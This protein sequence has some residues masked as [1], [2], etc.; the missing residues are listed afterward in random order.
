MAIRQK[1]GCTYADYSNTIDVRSGHTLSGYIKTR[2]P[3]HEAEY[4][5]GIIKH[6][7]ETKIRII[8]EHLKQ[9]ELLLYDFTV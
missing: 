6:E 2:C 1:C 5:A 7:K 3:E 8:K 4:Q 9:I